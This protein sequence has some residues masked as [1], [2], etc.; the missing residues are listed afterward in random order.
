MLIRQ[1]RRLDQYQI[2]P[3]IASASPRDMP[4]FL[5]A[6]FTL[7]DDKAFAKYCE[8]YM[9]YHLIRKFFLQYK[10]YTHL[11]IVPDDLIIDRVQYEELR[12]TVEN[13][14]DKYPILSGTCNHNWN[15]RDHLITCKELPDGDAES[16]NWMPVAEAD[17]Y[18]DD[19]IQ[20]VGFDGFSCSFIRRDVVEKISIEGFK[21]Q[22][23]YDRQFAIDCKALD[24]PIHVDTSIRFEHL[25]MRTGHMKFEHW[26]V[27]FK[28][29]RFV[30][31]VTRGPA[32]RRYKGFDELV[33][34]FDKQVNL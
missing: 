15:D 13:N 22:M 21:K 34:S 11:V 18:K 7:M 3:L 17:S 4:E 32:S 12:A 23:A 30:V 27:G 16:Y 24:I 29:P 1:E 5:D 10:R 28:E 2:I 9:A 19:P 26:G 14:Q 31:E 8:E 6:M 20:Q 25:G 33:K